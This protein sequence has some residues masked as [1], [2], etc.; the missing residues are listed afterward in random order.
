MLL[1]PALLNLPTEPAG[2]VPVPA[3]FPVLGGSAAVVG[4]PYVPS[5]P[6]ACFV[7][8]ETHADGLSPAEPLTDSARLRLPTHSGQRHRLTLFLIS[9]SLLRTVSQFS[10]EHA[11]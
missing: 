6:S 8:T 1:E 5:L 11:Y 7:A 9:C 4:R 2:L 10:G 3:R